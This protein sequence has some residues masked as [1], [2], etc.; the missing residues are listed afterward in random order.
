[1][2]GWLS[3]CCARGLTRVIWILVVALIGTTPGYAQSIWELTPYKVQTWVVLESRPLI[4]LTA[5]ALLDRQLRR[6]A[7]SALGAVWD[8]QVEEAPVEYR[9]DFFALQEPSPDSLLTEFPAIDGF[10]ELMVVV[11]KSLV[12]THETETLGGDIEWRHWREMR[13]CQCN[14]CLVRLWRLR[15]DRHKRRGGSGGTAP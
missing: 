12:E 11:R 5:A 6:S 8:L 9:S 13:C 2:I 4:P 14:S 15:G 7:D 3:T 1:M 10:D